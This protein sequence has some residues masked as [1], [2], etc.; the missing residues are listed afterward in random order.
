MKKF[1]SAFTVFLFVL[2]LNLGSIARAENA[3]AAQA[4][5]QGNT[6]V[7]STEPA[8][9]GQAAAMAADD[10][11]DDDSP[12]CNMSGKACSRMGK[13][14]GGCMCGP[15]CQCANCMMK[16]GGMMHKPGCDCDMCRGRM[17]MGMGG[18]R[19][20]MG[21]MMAGTGMVRS[22][23][24]PDY[25]LMRRDYLNLSQEQAD[26]LG[27]LD[28]TMRKEAILKGA[29]VKALEL[30]LSGI[31][32][33]TDF[34]VDDAI[35]KLKDVEAARL[36]LRTAMIKI[37]GEARD[38]LSPEQLDKLKSVGP[39]NGMCGN[40]CGKKGGMKD[41]MKKQMMEKMMKKQMGQ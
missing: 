38:L 13:M 27:K 3:P 2:A 9:E 11:D 6:E 22:C 20:G 33:A 30:D 1:A 31:V 25:Y 5:P 28:M 7:Q 10:A 23:R 18:M 39:G 32:T 24:M 12:M 16:K 41:D 37:A 35:A 4:A 21:M 34:K 14:S 36:D 8:D 40:M 26:N 19:G 29:Q 17:G 15:D